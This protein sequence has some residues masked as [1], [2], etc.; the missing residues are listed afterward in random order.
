[1][2]IDLEKGTLEVTANES[3]KTKIVKKWHEFT[4]W[5]FGDWSFKDYMAWFG[6]CSMLGTVLGY[7]IK[8]IIWLV[9]RNKK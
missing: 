1:M 7:G 5:Y 3:I 9:K 6:F 2:I 4:D 8:G